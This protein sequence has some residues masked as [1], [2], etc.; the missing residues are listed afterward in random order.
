MATPNNDASS[1][2]KV[3]KNLYLTRETLDQAKAIKKA[4]RRGSVS[5]VVDAVINDEY[6][7]L[8]PEGEDGV[9]NTAQKMERAA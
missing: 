6:K 1:K 7:R 5:N 2:D 3:R 9:S 4:T 8:F